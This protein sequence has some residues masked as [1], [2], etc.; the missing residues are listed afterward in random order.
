MCTADFI[1]RAKELHGSKYDYSNTV[2]VSNRE[3]VAIG[4]ST[5]G[6]VNIKANSH[7][8]GRGCHL[9]AG[10]KLKNT[11]D[12][13]ILSRAL[14]GD[15]YDYSKSVYTGARGELTVSC[16]THGDWI[17]TPSVHKKSGCPQCA[18]DGFKTCNV[19]NLSNVIEASRA[20]HKTEFIFDKSVYVHSKSS[21][22]ITCPVHGDFETTPNYFL[23]S[24]YSCPRCTLGLHTSIGE[25][26]MAEFIKSLDVTI[27]EN[28][29]ALI[30]PYE[31]DILCGNVGIEYNGVYYHN[32]NFKCLE[33]SKRAKEIN[34]QLLHFWDIEWNN[35]QDIV[36]SIIK[37]KLCKT[38]KLFARKC[39]IRLICDKEYRPFCDSNHLQ[40]YKSAKVMIG[41]F[42]NESLVSAMS[43]SPHKSYEWELVRLCSK[44]N[45]TIIGGASRMF[46]YFRKS[47][48]PQSV[49]TFADARYATGHV[50][51]TLG[52]RYLK[53][54]RPN[55]FYIK[56][57]KVL[58]RM[59]CQKHKL[60]KLLDNFDESL[61]EKQN[62][63]NHN[64]KCV[65]DVGNHQFM[66][67]S[68]VVNPL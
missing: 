7:L 32:D 67:K 17:T 51:T 68:S 16:P 40:G 25:K 26:Q 8:N 41:L 63:I 36:K 48:N 2:Y 30:P 55:Y 24:A 13:I 47:Y 5:H 15:K 66:W 28:D 31:I 38:S 14:H 45:Y 18:I 62:M 46:S 61:S 60:D 39:S 52:F 29:R 65:Y 37:S 9:C 44:L 35:K 43:F 58:S 21:M 27:V 22:I 59:S 6:L 56:N 11:D 50:Y 33:K 53:T 42:D 3:K 10:N 4:C 64:Y 12:F 49:M 23:Q 1:K 34:W 54:T 19:S 57:N 20:K